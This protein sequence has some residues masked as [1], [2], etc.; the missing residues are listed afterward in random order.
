MVVESDASGRIV[1]SKTVREAPWIKRN[2][3]PAS[4]AE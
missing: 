3:V 4:R 1:I 2:P